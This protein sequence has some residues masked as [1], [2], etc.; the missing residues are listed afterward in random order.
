[1]RHEPGIS[2]EADVDID[3][4]SDSGNIKE[5]EITVDDSL[6]LEDHVVNCDYPITEDLVELPYKVE[7]EC[8]ETFT[9]LEDTAAEPCDQ[10]PP[11]GNEVLI[12]E[13]LIISSEDD[14]F[15]T[16]SLE[17]H[18]D[19]GVELYLDVIESEVC[20]FTDGFGEEEEVSTNTEPHIFKGDL[21]TPSGRVM[22]VIVD[23]MPTI[24]PSDSNIG[25]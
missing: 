23:D 15:V 19:Q 2:E 21:V 22:T 3:V 5:E 25:K 4:D 9:R 11:I 14:P 1:M 24:Y 6:T 18:G 12:K 7:N 8:K 13:E 17:L 16:E 20:V 10:K